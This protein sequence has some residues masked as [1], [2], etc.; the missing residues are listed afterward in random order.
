MTCKVG[1]GMYDCTGPAAEQTMMGYA[2]A[3]QKTMGIA[4]RQWV[5]AFIIKDKKDDFICIA[6][7]DI[8]MIF[9]RIKDEVIKRISKKFNGVLKVN[10]VLLSAI[11]TH[12]GPAGYSHYPTFDIISKGFSIQTFEI[13]VDG[14]VQAIT[15]A[16]NNMKPA[17]MYIN[18]C[19]LP[20]CGGQRSREAWESNPEE[21]RELYGDTDKSFTLL[22]FIDA[23]GRLFGTIAYFALHCTSIGIHNQLISSD[24]RGFAS[25]TLERMFGNDP[26]KNDP[27]FIAAFPN[28]NGGDVSP[29][30][31]I[32]HPPGGDEDYNRMKEISDK[33]VQKTL[34]LINSEAEEVVGDIKFGLTNVDMANVK[35]EGTDRRTCDGALGA[36]FSGASSE[37]NASPVPI[38][39]EGLTR[40]EFL[41]GDVPRKYSFRRKFLTFLLDL[42]WHDMDDPEWVKAQGEKPILLPVGRAKYRG[43]PFFPQ[44]FPLQILKLGSICIVGFPGEITSIAGI[45]LKNT[46][47]ST[48]KGTETKYCLLNCYANSFSNY[49][50]TKEEYS[51]Q[52]YEGASTLFGPNQLEAYQQEYQKIAEKIRDNL[53]VPLGASFPKHKSRE[54]RLRLK[55]RYDDDPMGKNYG[56]VLTQPNS[57]YSYNEKVLVE[58]IGANPR[59]NPRIMDTFLEVQRKTNNKWVT[60][61][62]DLDF[63]T[64]YH[65]KR[66]GIAHSN[67]TIEWN[68]PSNELPGEYRIIHKGDWKSHWRKKITPYIGYTNSFKVLKNSNGDS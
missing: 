27:G 53:N 26:Y 48:F 65:W 33:L 11:H 28:A 32:G 68:I 40:S 14:F 15:R 1:V 51:Q 7:A 6:V 17:K 19:E 58:F 64:I 62:K 42:V 57:S 16:W 45:R 22:K 23:S 50:T 38:F 46:I 24:N 54:K 2:E 43:I 20:N 61:Y 31:G 52:H 60:I 35:I 66:K 29:N 44:I 59:N 49:T 47:L 30:V 37:D 18:T 25:R 41:K 63:E 5:R 55:V 36:S 67:I 56:D 4:D 3:K 9:Q 13:I 34:L 12:S 10:N 8:C 21:E 39:I